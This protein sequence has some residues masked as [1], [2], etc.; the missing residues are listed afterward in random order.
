MEHESRLNKRAAAEQHGGTVGDRSDEGGS[1]LQLQGHNRA[2]VKQKRICWCRNTPFTD[3]GTVALMLGGGRD[4]SASEKEGR[5]REFI[6]F[7]G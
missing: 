3:F 5:N 6:E 1:S 7:S 4:F 2:S